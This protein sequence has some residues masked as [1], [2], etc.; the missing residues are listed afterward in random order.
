MN[1]MFIY[2]E[3]F[4][5]NKDLEIQ[6]H[7]C[8]GIKYYTVNNF[9]KNFDQ[10]NEVMANSYSGNWR[11]CENSRN[12]IDYYDCRIAF[13]QYLTTVKDAL[14]ELAKRATN[15]HHH[16]WEATTDVGV[17]TFRQINKK[18]SDFAVPHADGGTF[19]G[20]LY[21]NKPEECSGGTAFIRSK[22]TNSMENV[23]EYFKE[24]P[25]LDETGDDYWKG[26]YDD[27]EIVGTVPM[28]S[29]KLFMLPSKFT[30]A[31]WHPVDSFYDFTRLTAVWSVKDYGPKYVG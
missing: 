6:E 18:R 25:D 28:E 10:A 7:N 23:M 14:L 26:S 15:T 11:I 29:N 24:R 21:M 1:K 12:G 27:W 8:E 13:T 3:V 30:H 22:H 2:D 5:V 19:T 16:N 17:N 4:E 20:V 31:A 9:L